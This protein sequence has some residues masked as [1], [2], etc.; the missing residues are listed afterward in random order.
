M[1]QNG[2]LFAMD[3]TAPPSLAPC[4]IRPPR[5]VEVQILQEQISVRPSI[6]IKKADKSAFLL[7]Y[8]LASLI[9]EKTFI[10]A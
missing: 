3:I 4:G 1:Q 7:A 6:D 10:K 5:M 8:V 2:G 9:G